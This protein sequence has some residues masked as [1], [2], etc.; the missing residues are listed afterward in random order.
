MSLLI[1]NGGVNNDDTAVEVAPNLISFNAKFDDRKSSYGDGSL[2]SAKNPNTSFW[3]L[4]IKNQVISGDIESAFYLYKQMREIGV[5]HDN[6]TFPIIN[7]ALLLSPESFWLGKIIHALAFRTGFV[8]DVYFCNTMIKTFIKSGCF[9]DACKLFGEMLYRD[10]VSWTTLISG[11]VLEGNVNGA[12]RLFNEMRNEVEPNAVTMLTI[13]QACLDL[14]E[15]KQVHAYL[16]KNGW[17]VDQSVGNSILKMYSDLGSVDDAEILFEEMDKRDIVSWNIMLSLYSAGGEILTMV[18]CFCEMQGKVEPSSE[19][20]TVFLSGIVQ[21]RNLYHGRQIHCLA[22]KKGI[23]D[24]KLTTALVDFY[25]KCGELEM[26]AQFFGEICYSSY[27]T[28]NAM[29]SGL[30]ENGMFNEVLA[31]FKQMLAAGFRPAGENLCSLVITYT[32]IG[33]IK[34]GKG[35]HGYVIRNL[36]V[37]SSESTRNLETSILNMYV[38]CG[39]ISAARNCFDGMETK[40]VIAWT[41]M[42]EGYGTHGFGL[43][44]LE[45]FIRMVDEGIKPNGITFLSLLSACSHSGL[46]REGCEI[47][48]SMKWKFKIEPDLDHY[49]CIVDLLGRC[50]RVKEALAVILKWVPFPDTGIWGSVVAASRVHMEK[51]LG[52]YAAMKLLEIEDDNVGYCTL[53]SNIEASAENWGEVEQVRD[54]MKARDLVKKPGWSCI[55]IK[56]GFLQGFISGDRS[57]PCFAA[58]HNTLVSLIRMDS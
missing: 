2:K 23:C 17:L 49:T 8:T 28:W 46:L 14:F 52:E 43:Q 1:S 22:T 56:A 42:I 35:V 4:S 45:S 11:H 47:L 40:D 15:G 39:G 25:S 48:Y 55:E 3:N 36:Y 29:I 58:I 50:G 18:H 30:L 34:L 26:A 5:Q 57:H 19:A 9:G 21:G 31:L 53:I 44:A 20:L 6:Y 12:F 16:K 38:R 27:I 10:M 54:S 7:Q 51:R 33:A 32:R 24:D 37:D 41:S 13:L